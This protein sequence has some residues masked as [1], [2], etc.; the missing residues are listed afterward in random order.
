M[1][2]LSVNLSCPFYCLLNSPVR[3]GPQFY[4]MTIIVTAVHRMHQ[5]DWPPSPNTPSIDADSP[6]DHVRPL[7]YKYQVFYH[8]LLLLNQT[9]K[10]CGFY[11]I[12]NYTIAKLLLLEYWRPHVTFTRVI[13][14]VQLGFLYQC[15]YAY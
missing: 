9:V 13:S 4:Y 11:T 10:S 1:D 12:N 14:D 5:F 2:Q 8:I 3:I 7:L 6:V 15:N